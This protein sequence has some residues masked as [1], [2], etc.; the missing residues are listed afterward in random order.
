MTAAGLS[1]ED[2]KKYQKRRDASDKP[3]APTD[4]LVA[5]S[6]QPTEYVKKALSLLEKDDTIEDQ[7][8]H[9]TITLMGRGKA[10][11]TV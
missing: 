1:R 2:K 9:K 4:I 5:T 10:V 7:V 3:D 8:L 11:S 6:A